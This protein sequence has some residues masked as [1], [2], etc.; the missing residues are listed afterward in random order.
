MGKKA[1][2]S[3]ISTKR[4][5]E[6]TAKKLKSKAKVA[7]GRE[8]AAKKASER[9]SKAEEK[10]TKASN[11]ADLAMK[12]CNADQCRSG[13]ACKKVGSKGPF[14]CSDL[15]TCCKTKPAEKADAGLA[16]A[17]FNDKS[18]PETKFKEPAFTM[19]KMPK[20]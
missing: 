9:G 6:A 20:E 17:G 10:Q 14:F 19:P 13:N 18:F 3:E 2:A 15:V 4:G 11:K 5:K 16:W 8:K 1:R 7:K 12:S